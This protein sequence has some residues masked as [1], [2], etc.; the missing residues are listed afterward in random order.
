MACNEPDDKTELLNEIR[1]LEQ[2]IASLEEERYLLVSKSQLLQHRV[3]D[4][5]YYLRTGIDPRKP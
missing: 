3:D 4:L 2:Q 5:K 1:I